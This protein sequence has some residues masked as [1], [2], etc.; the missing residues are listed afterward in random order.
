MP[1]AK[2]PAQPVKKP[3]GAARAPKTAG[4]ARAPQPAGPDVEW[5]IHDRFGLFIHWGLYALP[6]AQTTAM[7]RPI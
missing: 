6:M 4:K 3:A 1:A 7:N 2:K 5:F